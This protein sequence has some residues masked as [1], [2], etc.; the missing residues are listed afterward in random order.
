MLAYCEFYETA[1][2]PAALERLARALLAD[3]EHEGIQL[4]ARDAG[5]RAVGFASVFWTWS[6][7][8]AARLAVMNDLY[9]APEA[10]G[11][12]TAEALMRACMERG[13]AHGACA[14]EW[15]TAPDNHRAQTLYDRFGGVRE[16]WV[17][18][19]VSL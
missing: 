11:T 9:V 8:R 13:R 2:E 12:G 5:G 14:L 6:T 1:P 10:R 4:I 18:Y 16:T 7:V 19:G 3:P 17:D 15:Q